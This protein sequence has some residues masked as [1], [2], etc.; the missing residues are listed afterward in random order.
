MFMKCLL[1]VTIVLSCLSF[2]SG[3]EATP[4]PAY[5]LVTET[6]IGPFEQAYMEEL[7][8]PITRELWRERRVLR[9]RFDAPPTFGGMTFMR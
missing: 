7:A 9:V 3:D 6:A 2:C 1:S 4:Y 8:F 5:E